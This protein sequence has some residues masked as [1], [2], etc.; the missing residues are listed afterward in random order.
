M[1]SGLKLLAIGIGVGLVCILGLYVA[2]IYSAGHSI[3]AGPSAANNTYSSVPVNSSGITNA[4]NNMD[5]ASGEPARS[6]SIYFGLEYGPKKFYRDANVTLYRVIGYNTS[7]NDDDLS[8]V[9]I[10]GNPMNATNYVISGM[11]VYRFDN[12]PAGSYRV[13]G[14]KGGKT[15]TG[16]LNSGSFIYLT[17]DDLDIAIPDGVRLVN[18]TIY[19]F[20]RDDTGAYLPGV[21]VSLSGTN[22]RIG[23]PLDGS[24]VSNRSVVSGEGA[25]VGF[26]CFENLA[27]GWYTITCEKDG[28]NPAPTTVQFM[29]KDANGT[30]VR[31]IMYR[32][33]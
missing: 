8:F 13:I 21:V 27:P 29:G 25:H 5:I 1:R 26:Y 23:D 7:T 12:V 24:S 4:I 3:S 16:Y 17:V 2:L 33:R 20:V 22:S 14:E 11:P 30:E 10:P 32:Q 15:W 9:D 6:D 28:F 19:G 18:S 31:L